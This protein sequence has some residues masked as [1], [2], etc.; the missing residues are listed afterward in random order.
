MNKHIILIL[1]PNF[2]AIDLGAKLVYWLLNPS[3][4]VYGALL[5][6][7]E[8]WALWRNYIQCLLRNEWAMLCW[9]F[10]V[11]ADE[12]VSLY[13]MYI[14]LSLPHLES[15]LKRNRFRWYLN[16]SKIIYFA[17]HKC[18]LR[19]LQNDIGNKVV[20]FKVER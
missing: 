13:N 12:H 6:A 18:M 5:H 16:Q 8:C 9:M 15:R 11:K 20:F 4:Y 7:G 3:G 10:R 17:V 1:A 2:T 14:Q 19:N